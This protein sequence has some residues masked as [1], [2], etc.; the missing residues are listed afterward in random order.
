MDRIGRQLLEEGKAAIEQSRGGK[1]YTTGRRDVL[2]LLLKVNVGEDIPANKRLSDEAVLAR[3]LIS[4]HHSLR[5]L[6]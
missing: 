5:G 4:T 3:T 6:T 1:K 2:S